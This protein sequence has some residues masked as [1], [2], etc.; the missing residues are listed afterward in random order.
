MID[1]TAANNS[2]AVPNG[3]RRGTG[4]VSVKN[5]ATPKL[6]GTAIN[7]AIKAVTTVPK[8]AIKPPNLPLMMS[9][10]IVKKNPGPNSLR[11]G[12]ALTIKEMMMPI[13]AKSTVRAKNNVDLWK[14]KS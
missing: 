2:T 1:G 7:K 9:H 11:A 12:Q 14:T 13:S 10:S 4:H 6:S 8:I 5:T 3:R